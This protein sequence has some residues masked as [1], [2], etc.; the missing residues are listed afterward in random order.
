MDGVNILN[1]IE[2]VTIVNDTFNYTAASIALLV[3]VAIGG[4]AGFFIGRMNCEAAAIGTLVGLVLS[5]FTG[6]LFGSIF[7]YPPETETTMRYEV[8]VDDSVSMKEF[9][10]RYEVIESRGQI[11][12]IEEKE[13]DG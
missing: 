11:Y 12:V 7:S 1:G 3:T 6:S 8:T 4:V 5:V 13:S 10:E 2:V 9:Y